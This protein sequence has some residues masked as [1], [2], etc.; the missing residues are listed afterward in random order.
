MNKQD[1]RV[2]RTLQ[3]I[4]TAFLELLE[5]KGFD[6]ITV[7]DILDRTQIN[8]STFYKHFKN[9]DEVA[10]KL[11]EEVKEKFR[12]NFKHRFSISTKTFVQMIAP[13]YDQYHH[14]VRLIGSIRTT[15]IHL[16]ED[17]YQFI[18]QRYISQ[19]AIKQDKT[20]EELMFQGHLFATISIGVMKYFI[21]QG[22]RP[23]P[24][25]VFD[26]IKSVVDLLVIGST[27]E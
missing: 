23:I 26:D 7:Q 12:E 4:R 13:I 25:E 15:K 10:L 18:Q 11:V 19:A 8:R 21:E 2:V 1:I 6:S 20:E 17:L 5:E 9:K 3:L 24:E 16:Y 27:E 22:E 14:L